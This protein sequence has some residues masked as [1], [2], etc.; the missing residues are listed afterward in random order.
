[1][2]TLLP[3]DPVFYFTITNY[4]LVDFVNIEERLLQTIRE[5]FEIEK[6]DREFGTTIVDLP[7]IENQMIES[8]ARSEY[9]NIHC[10]EGFVL[11]IK[12]YNQESDTHSFENARKSVSSTISITVL[13]NHHWNMVKSSYLLFRHFFESPGMLD[14]TWFYNFPGKGIYSNYKSIASKE[15]LDEIARL[16]EHAILQKQLKMKFNEFNFQELP[17]IDFDNIAPLIPNKDAIHSFR[18][19]DCNL[20]DWPSLLFECENVTNINL[21]NNHIHLCD[22]RIKNLTKLRSITLS[23]NPILQDTEQMNMLK[24][25]LPENCRIEK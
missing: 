18:I 21:Y 4:K 6:I 19:S 1:M 14:N 12:L 3:F 16:T 10:K 2:T 23:D 5:N 7:C 24:T 20:T 8:Y 17:Y 15:V 13:K 25:F 11:S 9:I 22:P